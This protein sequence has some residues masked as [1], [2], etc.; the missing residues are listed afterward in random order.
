MTFKTQNI[1]YLVIYR[2]FP[3]RAVKDS[4]LFVSF[5]FCFWVFSFKSSNHYRFMNI[6][7][8]STSFS[9]TVSKI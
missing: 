6:I 1:Y 2:S 5:L 9:T 4:F 7:A 3:I 8:S